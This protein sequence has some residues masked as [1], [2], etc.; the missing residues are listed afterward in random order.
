MIPDEDI[1]LHIAD[2]VSEY[3]ISEADSAW[4]P[5]IRLAKSAQFDSLRPYRASIVYSPE[6]QKFEVSANLY[7][8]LRD[9]ERNSG[10]W[11]SE[12]I[13]AVVRGEIVGDQ[14]KIGDVALLTADAAAR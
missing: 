14:V 6:T 11:W 12:T 2:A 8:T 4:K 13:P 3:R 7:L 9:P 5:V 10:R 1:A